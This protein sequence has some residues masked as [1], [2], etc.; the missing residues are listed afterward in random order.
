MIY[1]ELVLT[2]KLAKD[3]SYYSS[4]AVIAKNINQTMVL[5]EELRRLHEGKGYKNYVFCNFYPTEKSK[6]Y[7]KGNIYLFN[8]RSPNRQLIFKMKYLLPKACTDFQVLATE[9][10]TYSPKFITEISNITPAICTLEGGRH[11][12]KENGIDLIMD[13]MHANAVKKA[14]GYLGSLFEQPKESFIQYIEQL[15]EK[16]IRLSYKQTSLIG[17]R[18]TI[19]VKT[20]E[21]SQLLA[22]IILGTGVLE[23]NSIG[24]GYCV[25]K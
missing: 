22:R 6:I 15:N 18:F 2:A 20:D 4:Q 17:N 8:L 21:E 3:I 13:R 25:F 11:W 23:K 14:K 5:D 1:Y 12:T 10:R 9:I 7:Q 19:G 24:L 16:P